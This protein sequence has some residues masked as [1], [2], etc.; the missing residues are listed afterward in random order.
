LNTTALVVALAEQ[1][2]I[3]IENYRLRQRAEEGVI[4]EE[5]QRLA[6][7]LHD[8]ITQ[9]IYAVTLFA[10]SSVDALEAGNIDKANETLQEVERN[11]L[12]A[13]KEM[14]LLLHQLQPLALEEGGLQ[15]AIDSRL[16]QVERRLGITASLAISEGLLLRPRPEE[17]V[18]R[19]VTEALNN[20]LKYADAS[21]ISISLQENEG[22]LRL[23]VK[24]N[25]CGFD[26][27]MP[28]L[29][30]GISNMQER[31]AILR[32]RFTLTSAPGQGTIISVDLPAECQE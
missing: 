6:R 14:R 3:I 9:S 30:M 20:S 24:D 16:N 28:K 5:R 22:H 29:G 27:A 18:Y 11:A 25:G 4:I 19:I 1:L 32:G 23:E 2:G 17:S 21:E 15:R 13:Q 12:F 31:V 8:A 10:R 26:P 7:D